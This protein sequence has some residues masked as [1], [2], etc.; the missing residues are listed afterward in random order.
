MHS[1]IRPRRLFPI[2]TFLF[3]ILP[4]A[5]NSLFAAQRPERTLEQIKQVMLYRAENH[6]YPMFGINLADA[7]EALA[8]IKARGKDQWAAAWS[9]IGD[10]YMAKA[11]ALAAS[12]PKEADE[13]YLQ[14]WHLYSMGAWPVQSSPGKERAYK[15][16]IAAFLAYARSWDPPL[17]VIHIP[18]EGKEITGYLRTPK[19]AKGPVP[20]A[21][22]INGLDSRKEGMIARFSTLLPYGIGIFATDSP[23]GGQAPIKASPNADRMYT[24]I[25]SYLLARPDVDKNRLALYGG[26]LGA[27]WSTKLA[28]T[29]HAR[30]CCV[31]SQSAAVDMFWTKQFFMNNVVGNREYPFDFAPALMTI[32][33]GVTT[34]QQMGEA[35][36]TMSLV[37]QHLIGG[38]TPPMLLIAGAKD[39]Q[40]P[41]SDTYLLLSSG[42]DP[43]DAWINPLGG[44]MGR[45]RSAWG[46]AV[47]YQKVVV[48]WL[49]R[50]LGISPHQG[51]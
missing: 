37:R 14:A 23:G 31:I 5:S 36:P 15:K 48:P 33:K 6:M 44:H 10:H 13:N 35:L 3:L 24:P 9:A 12:N 49:L 19:N 40:V 25:I 46:D 26:S 30:L 18:F 47:I 22:L 39:T 41:P 11:N 34:D 7:R 20:V 32:F 16:A 8:S 43:K 17:Q 21:L 51:D 38:P 2:G 27:Y 50:H 42:Q 4:F 29:E 28:F 1:F 45:D